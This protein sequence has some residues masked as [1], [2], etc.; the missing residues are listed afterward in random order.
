MKSGELAKRSGTCRVCEGPITYY[1]RRSEDVVPRS[2]AV[3]EAD[4]W[5]HDVLEDWITR[6]H[7]ARPR[8]AVA[9]GASGS[10][11]SALS[12]AGGRRS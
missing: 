9:A 6:P 1:P 8:G 12:V 2:C 4:R 3:D 11:S 10:G 5:S 7:R